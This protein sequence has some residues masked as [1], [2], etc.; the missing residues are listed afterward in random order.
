MA[1]G[2]YKES[3]E[4]SRRSDWYSYDVINEAARE[5]ALRS[6]LRG[7][8]PHASDAE[9]YKLAKQIEPKTAHA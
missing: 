2:A 1:L 9:F 5:R 6:F 4:P 8:T 3:L 7:L